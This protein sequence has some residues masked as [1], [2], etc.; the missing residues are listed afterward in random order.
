MYVTCIE[1]W[2][3]AGLAGNLCIYVCMCAHLYGRLLLGGPQFLQMCTCICI[4]VHMYRTFH[5]YAYRHEQMSAYTWTD[6]ASSVLWRGSMQDTSTHIYTCTNT[7]AFTYM[8]ADGASC[9]LRWGH[10][11]KAGVCRI[12]AY[13][14]WNKIVIVLSYECCHT[15]ETCEV[16]PPSPHD[17]PSRGSHANRKSFSRCHMAQRHSHLLESVHGIHK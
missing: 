17:E 10:I 8:R 4:C 1:P 15:Y 5:A 12:A 13:W 2:N 6:G 11:P 14:V 3:S 7:Y 9:I 16:S